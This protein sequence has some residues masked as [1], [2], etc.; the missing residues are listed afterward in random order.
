MVLPVV[1][2][3]L[4]E[5]GV[6]LVRDVLWVTR[7]DGLRLV[8]LLVGGLLLL[9]LL[10]LLLLWL[11]VIVLDFFDLGLLSVLFLGDFLIV[12]NLL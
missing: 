5:G 12:F 10:C 4:V 9:D 2:E 11:V 3:T 1:G 7:P 8:Q 6:F